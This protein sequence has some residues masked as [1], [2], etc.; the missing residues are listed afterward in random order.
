MSN[1]REDKPPAQAIDGVKGRPTVYF[2]A[3]RHGNLQPA[4][5]VD[6]R[7]ASWRVKEKVRLRLGDGLLLF[8]SK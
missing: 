1:E 3:E 8:H 7:L 4:P 6:E 2:T 5:I